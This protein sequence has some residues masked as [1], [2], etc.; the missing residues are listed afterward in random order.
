MGSMCPWRALRP[1]GNTQRPWL[2]GPHSGRS[3]DGC[4][5]IP[6]MG[7]NLTP[8]PI[9]RHVTGGRLRFGRGRGLISRINARE[10]NR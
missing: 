5:G 2:S 1:V 9:S 3:A 4:M 6:R 10:G 7:T 8:V